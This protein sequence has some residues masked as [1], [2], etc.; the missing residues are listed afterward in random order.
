MLHPKTLIT[1][2]AIAAFPAFVI[3]S[4]NGFPNK[5]DGAIL[6]IESKADGFREQNDSSWTLEKYSDTKA[7]SLGIDD[8][9]NV[10]YA[11]NVGKTPADQS[12]IKGAKGE[13]C[14]KNN[15]NQTTENL[16]IENQIQYRTWAGFKNL[17]NASQSS[18]A[19]Q[20]D[21]G[22][23]VCIPFKIA[24][25]PPQEANKFRVKSQATISNS[26]RKN[27]EE[28]STFDTDSFK[29]PSVPGQATGSSTITDSIECPQNYTCTQSDAGPWSASGT[30]TI[31]YSVLIK[32]VAAACTLPVNLKN[33]VSLLDNTTQ[34]IIS[35][36]NVIPI[37]TGGC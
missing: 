20:V 33:T 21:A 31:N 3:F 27:H 28:R 22:K 4:K 36:T 13:V 24:F 2:A 19:T 18:D 9:Y 14:I 25:V 29:F 16:K 32:N 17:Q 34:K 5:H 7:L 12:E 35:S 11:L 37:N 26:Y 15:G 6:N 1:F 8:F 10:S 23:T 30:T